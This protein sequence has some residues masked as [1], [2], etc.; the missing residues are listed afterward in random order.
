MLDS[1]AQRKWDILHTFSYAYICQPP[2]QYWDDEEF[3]YQRDIL[4]QQVHHDVHRTDWKTIYSRY[5][6]YLPIQAAL[7]DAKEYYAKLEVGET[8][9]AYERMREYAERMDAQRVEMRKPRPLPVVVNTKKKK[10]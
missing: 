9:P 6:D 1:E 8:T 2:E 4:L 5:G 3:M 7:N 10:K